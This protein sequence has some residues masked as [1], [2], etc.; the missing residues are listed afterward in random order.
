MRTIMNCSQHLF[1]E[2]SSLFQL[3]LTPSKVQNV[4]VA[5]QMAISIPDPT[6]TQEG[7]TPTVK[8]VKGCATTRLEQHSQHQAAARMQAK[9][10][11]SL[12]TQTVPDQQALDL[13][14]V[15]SRVMGCPHY[16][17]STVTM[18]LGDIS[19]TQFI[20]LLITWVKLWK[21]EEAEGT[22]QSNQL[23]RQTTKDSREI[24][25]TLLK[26][27]WPCLLTG[28]KTILLPATTNLLPSPVFAMHT[29]LISAQ[30]SPCV[31]TSDTAASQW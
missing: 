15:L 22:L 26:L 16:P 30:K 2:R 8:S 28:I 21:G 3:S 24:A 11:P 31:H 10:F 13:F 7:R 12:S 18:S 20:S 1:L 5:S 17:P 25:P 6:G 4:T 9:A 14:N 29:V 27:S 23:S 19:A